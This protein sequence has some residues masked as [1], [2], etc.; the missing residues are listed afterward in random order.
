MTTM[1]CISGTMDVQGPCSTLLR[2]IC[3]HC[4]VVRGYKDG[5]GIWGD[6]HGVCP[7]CA[8][9]YLADFHTVRNGQYI[10]F[11]N[12]V[13]SLDVAIKNFKRVNKE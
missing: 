13:A 5:K 11:R 9:K 7:T 12:S 4:K 8:D 10:H 1:T 2:E 6:S 3:S